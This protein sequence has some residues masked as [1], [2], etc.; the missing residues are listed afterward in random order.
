MK[1]IELI[2]FNLRKKELVKLGQDIYLGPKATACKT[3]MKAALGHIYVQ[4]IA[5]YDYN[6]SKVT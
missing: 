2:V 1:K 4:F 6:I 3:P 5:G